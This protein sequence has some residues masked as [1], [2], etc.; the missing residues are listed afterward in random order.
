MERSEAV[1]LVS[2]ALSVIYGVFALDE[3]TYLPER[4]LSYV[5]YTNEWRSAQ[6]PSAV[7]YLP[8]LYRVEVGFLFV[9]IVIYLALA[10][11]LWNCGP[12]VERLFLAERGQ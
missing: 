3:I 7:A 4:L 6:S 9:R 10:L 1:R 2:R 11:A 8:T 12:W 5:H